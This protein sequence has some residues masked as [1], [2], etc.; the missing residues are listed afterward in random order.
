[1]TFGLVLALSHISRTPWFEQTAPLAAWIVLGTVWSAGLILNLI[2]IASS[3]GPQGSRWRS[4]GSHSKIIILGLLAL[5]AISV[6]SLNPF[7]TI[8]QDLGASSMM[9]VFQVPLP[10]CLILLFTFISA[11]A[12]KDMIYSS[13]H[14]RRAL[15]VLFAS[16]TILLVA[17]YFLSLF[18]TLHHLAT[19][20]SNPGNP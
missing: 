13:I 2:V 12:A 20:M 10:I 3:S 8:L 17:A 7:A 6:R 19:G 16:L 14:S 9:I 1:L 18:L 11:V 5:S 15:N 4:L